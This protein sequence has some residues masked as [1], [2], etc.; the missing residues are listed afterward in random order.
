[1]ALINLTN[2]FA[3][4]L[5]SAAYVHSTNFKGSGK[6]S[7][8]E[9]EGFEPQRDGFNTNPINSKFKT[10][11]EIESIAKSNPRI[12]ALLKEHNLP[13][14]VN[15]KALNELQKGHLAV[16]RTIAAKI[17]SALPAELKKEVNLP[18]LQQA[19][20]LHD[21]G[22]VLI[23]EKILGKAGSLNPDEKQVMELHSEF[24]YELLKSLGVS[25]GVLNLVKYHHQNSDKTG[26]PVADKDFE[27]SLSL[28]ILETAD[29]YSA[30]TEERPY[31]SACTKEEALE[32][33]KKDVESGLI[34]QDVF[35]ALVKNI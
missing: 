35:D 30:L 3:I 26:Y 16:T 33:I 19:A 24:G 22:K 6:V 9:Q 23:P 29:K 27:F 32:I 14:K 11:K 12:M 20:M 28:Q 7:A 21:Y 15:I 2:L 34:S 4:P 31:H 18:E 5:S 25:E 17:Y 13:L 1:M 8:F 10:T